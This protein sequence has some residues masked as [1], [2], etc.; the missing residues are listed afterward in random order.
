M[1][2]VPKFITSTPTMSS[3]PP[4][5]TDMLAAEILIP[6]PNS[7]FPT[8]YLYVSNRNDPSPEGD[9]IAIFD[10]V[11]NSSKL[12]LIAEVRSGLNHARGMLF[13]GENDKYLVIGGANGG[14]VKVFERVNDGM[15]LK[16]VAKNEGV[17]APTGFLW[18]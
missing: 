7:L 8:P 4:Q 12:Q 6:K 5:P 17:K 13:G 16:E 15:G 9:I 2:E 11:S 18:K 14:G 1:P 3:P 10:F